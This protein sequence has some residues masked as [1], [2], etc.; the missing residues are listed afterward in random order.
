MVAS[1]SAD[2]TIRL[3]DMD[4]QSWQKKACQRAGRNLTLTEWNAYY[5]EDIPYEPTC[6]QWPIP[7]DAQKHLDAR[8]ALRRKRT[9]VGVAGGLGI[10]DIIL[11]VWRRKKRKSEKQ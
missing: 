10:L 3:W 5:S 4:I 11:L 6:P 7:P 8:A 1:G 2:T 9:V